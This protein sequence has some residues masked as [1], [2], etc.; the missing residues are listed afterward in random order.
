MVMASIY[1]NVYSARRGPDI[2]VHVMLNL[3]KGTLTTYYIMK[4]IIL[5]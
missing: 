1:A 2:N 5:I 4:E 3:G